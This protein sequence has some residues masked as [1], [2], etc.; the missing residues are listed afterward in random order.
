MSRFPLLGLLL[1][2][3]MGCHNGPAPEPTDTS[4]PIEQTLTIYRLDGDAGRQPE[5]SDTFHKWLILKRH[6]ITDST[7][8]QSV[9]EAL[10]A[11]IDDPN[12]AQRR[13]FIPRHG[14][15]H[16]LP[17]GHTMDHVICFQCGSYHAY[18]DGVSHNGGAIAP[19]KIKRALDSI[20]Q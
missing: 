7:T 16:R 2:V 17:D 10:Q 11:G 19:T 15:R 3:L 5:S 1:C 9:L 4:T 18:L 6:T 13:C 12:A 20:L 8:Q 14:I